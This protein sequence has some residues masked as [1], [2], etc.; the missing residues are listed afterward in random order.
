MAGEIEDSAKLKRESHQLR[1]LSTD[2]D[3]RIPGKN[4][5]DPLM[6]DTI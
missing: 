5:Y 2:M 4:P 6:L 3:Q 1:R